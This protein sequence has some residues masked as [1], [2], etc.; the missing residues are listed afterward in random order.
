GGKPVTGH[1]LVPDED[2]RPVAGPRAGG[3]LGPDRPGPLVA[4]IHFA[5]PG[6]TVV[7]DRIY[8]LGHSGEPN[9]LAGDP[10]GVVLTAWW[11]SRIVV[12]GKCPRSLL[13][14][15]RS[16]QQSGQPHGHSRGGREDWRRA[17]PVL[18][19]QCRRARGWRGGA[20]QSGSG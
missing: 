5:V 3:D 7:R 10:R 1:G 2:H 17:A 16:H 9:A 18:A 15:G 19:G 12:R 4:P 8:I 11:G 14:A 20:G 13:P 6:V